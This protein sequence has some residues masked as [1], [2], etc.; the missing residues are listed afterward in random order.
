MF[1][2]CTINVRGLSES[3]FSCVADYFAKFKLDF[4]FLQETMI[5]DDVTCR[6]FSSRW[7]GPSYWA[8]AC[9]RRGG[10][11]ILCSDR[12]RNNVS[13]WQKDS[14]GRVLSILVTLDDIKLNL[15]NVYTPTYPAERKTFFQSLHPFFFPNSELILGGDFNCYDSPLDKMGGTARIDKSL[16]DLKSSCALRDAWRFKHPRERHFTWFNH[17]RTI[18]SRLDSFLISR[19]LC[20][21]IS[22]CKI[23]PC[24]RSD[25][26]FVILDL[27]LTG[28]LKHGPGVWKINNSLL[29]DECFRSS[30][31]DLIDT[32]ISFRH[33]FSSTKELWDAL[34]DDIKLVT[35]D[36]SRRRS[37]ERAR[38]KIL[39]TNR[40]IALKNRLALGLHS[41]AQEIL[42]L[43]ASLKAI[44]DKEL[45][46]SKIRS[47][48]KWL[49]EGELPSRY[50]FSLERQRHERTLVSSVFNTE[51]SE[52][53]SLP[54]IIEVH[55]KYYD[56]LFANEE[57]DLTVQ[58][59]LLSHVSARLPEAMRASCEGS[60]TLAEA[61]EALKLSN[62]NRTPGPD[63]LSI[64]FYLTFWSRL[65]PL[66]VDAFNEGL[67]EGVLCDSMKASV[68]RLVHK[69]DDRRLLKNW[70]PISLLNVDYKICS[71]A[72]SL[73]L[74]SVL[75]CIVNPDQTCSVP[76]RSI[77]SNVI[78]LRDC[79]NYIEQ[80][81]ETGILISLDQEKAFDRV[82]RSFMLRLLEHFGF[83]P[84]FVN[85]IRTLYNGAYTQILVND[86]LSKPVLL[87][88]G[89]RQGDALS[90]LL[91][92]LC[93]EVLAC[94][95]RASENI[96][97]FLL[98]GARGL[99][100]K[101]AQYA[102]DTTA[103]VKDY[104]SLVCLF[105]A[106]SLYERGTGAKL[107]R[108]KTKAMWLG[109]WKNCRDEPLGLT[110]VRKVKI[111][112]V[113]FGVENTERDNWEPRLS[114]L[115]KS[116]SLWRSRSLSL[117]GKV[118]I[119]NILGLSKLLFLS[120][121]M[122][123]PKWVVNKVNNLIWPFLWGS[124]VESVARRTILCPPLKGGLG[125]KDFVCQGKA[126][127]LAAFVKS[128]TDSSCKCFFVVRYFCGA[129]VA[130]L[131][132][133]WAGLRD[134]LTP[135][136]AR[137]T[138]FYSSV[139]AS[140]R[141]FSLP[142][143]FSFT[144]KSFYAILFDKVSIPAVLP[145]FW[146]P[147]CIP[148]FSMAR[149]WRFVRDGFSENYKN[150]LAWL[151]TLRAIKVRRSLRDWG[152]INSPKCASCVRNETIDHC[153]LHCARVKR[154][155]AFFLPLLSALL[156]SPFKPTCA[157]VFLYQFS[158]PGEK[159]LRI[160][161][162]LLKSIL[163]G[164]WKFRNKATFHNG[165]EN[166]RAIIKYIVVDIKR[167]I[168]VD[169]HR[170]SPTRFRS[171]WVHPAICNFRDHDNLVFFF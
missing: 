103:I 136:A 144:S 35:V 70:R 124:R 26:D 61:S 27:E 8:P 73:R 127:R 123:P 150:D 68:T 53:S 95:I 98:P 65:G 100:F 66:L 163:Y 125:L 91:Y 81:D 109:A 42:V 126:A 143:D 60:L 51:G 160:L 39:L 76:G 131:R 84:S 36:F 134:N 34:K 28:L 75:E 4:C 121:F 93:V 41:D 128:L 116:L 78:L 7:P 31:E 168:N 157:S 37:R 135:T 2:I 69:R 22:D 146:T 140:L 106:I 107:N 147:F 118:L 169:R 119:L 165:R 162:F 62:R 102:D 129:R 64:E 38:E 58:N 138:K 105:E 77:S 85:C 88:R 166:S 45:E 155:W 3:K 115:D 12:F 50:F 159:N 110:W 137:P 10:V 67:A 167:R 171:L 158:S 154:V 164:V 132:P 114:K 96:R 13:T 151:I 46:G 111:L 11:A 30:I 141:S 74:A 92:V 87:Q 44:Y 139:L 161:L 48:V 80:T 104:R 5:S 71:K 9:R 79:L 149:H 47:R 108:S 112:G 101:V 122:Q 56:N 97:G 14:D 83:G 24:L 94:K 170:F 19:P 152:Y 89:V 23:W 15:V 29:E 120:R 25:H 142:P 49:E 117:L 156:N 63:G 1:R 17:N 153:F 82:N 148:R 59:E 52:V 72:I 33:V 130:S 57:I 21:Q 133:E 145:G 16:S 20:G 90:P 54:E 86:F 18:A 40:L 99:Q 43:E 32:F 6:S 55:E 113:V